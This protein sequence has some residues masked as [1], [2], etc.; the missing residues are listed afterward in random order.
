V[1]QLWPTGHAEPLT[2]EELR[3][4]YDHQPREEPW[5]R[6]NF[7]TSADGAVTVAERSAG[8]SSEADKKVFGLLRSLSDVLL[9]GAGTLRQESYGPVQLDQRRRAWRREAGLA[10]VPTLALVS[11]R[12]DLNPVH[13][14][15]AEA[16]VRPIVFTHGG[17]PVERRDALAAVADVI[18]VGDAE[19][20]L[21]AARRVLIE[22]EFRQILNEGGPHLFGSLLAADAVDELCL[23]VAPLLAGP[24]AG[25]IIAGPSAARMET[26]PSAAPGAVDPET[27]PRPEAVPGVPHSLRLAHVLEADGNLL[28]R[29]TRR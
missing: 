13:P 15:L 12:L 18:V 4:A 10:E 25:R 9:V 28:V 7:V 1:R 27:G 26:T 3:A 23:T 2:D 19:V 29:Y 20:D 22:R 11:S 17:S 14:A 8:L 21:A 16:P 24:G 5:L 6:V